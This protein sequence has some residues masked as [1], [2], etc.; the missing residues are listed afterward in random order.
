MIESIKTGT[1]KAAVDEVR[2]CGTK[3]FD[4]C[5]RQ[6]EGNN[7]RRYSKQRHLD[8]DRTKVQ[9]FVR[10]V[11]GTMIKLT[12]TWIL[13]ITRGDNMKAFMKNV[14]IRNILTKTDSSRAEYIQTLWAKFDEII[15]ELTK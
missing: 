1:Q 11:D 15:E 4:L 8:M 7:K 10:V 2:R 13:W 5:L 12:L 9:V 14:I 3:S 6:Q